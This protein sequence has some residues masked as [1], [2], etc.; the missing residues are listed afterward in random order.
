[1]GELLHDSLHGLQNKYDS[2][3]GSV[4]GKGLVAGV[5]IIKNA[6]NEPDGELAWDITN[7]CFQKGLLMFAPVG[8]GG[9]TVK[10]CPPLVISEELI[11]EGL[12]VLDES[13][14]ENL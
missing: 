9:A 8:F 4:Q 10:I 2:V 7:S 13:I 11:G 14:E 6:A 12:A 3:I 1:M 5:H